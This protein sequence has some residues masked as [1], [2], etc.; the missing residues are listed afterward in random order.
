M[1][2]IPHMGEVIMPE[3]YHEIEGY[4]CRLA[5]RKFLDLYYTLGDAAV[6]L[7]Y[8]D[9]KY[10]S[11]DDREVQILR[12]M[13]TRYSIIDLN[14]AFDL[15]LQVPWFYY[16]IGLC[17]NPSILR[18]TD[19]WVERLEKKCND[20]DTISFLENQ[21]DD[22]IIAIGQQIKGFRSEYIDNAMKSFT[23]RSLSNDLKHHKVI[24]IKEFANPLTFSLLGA[25]FFGLETNQIRTEINTEFFSTS[26]PDKALGKIKLSA[27]S[28]A[29]IDVEYFGG[30]LFRGCDLDNYSNASSLDDIFIETEAYWN[31]ILD[32]YD[33]L[34]REIICEIPSSPFFEKDKVKITKESF[35]LNDYHRSE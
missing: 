32:L 8:A 28:I 30:E 17:K 15:L 26:D 12:R 18:N 6:S 25:E 11:K 4:D 16:R 1:K 7:A 14:N 29:L 10:Y 5:I 9:K 2:P 24:P 23:I 33:T 31:A 20:K 13:Y 22:A 21:S 35:N 3:Y 34:Y 27:D 19:G